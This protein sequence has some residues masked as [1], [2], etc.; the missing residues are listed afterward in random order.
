[1]YR[2]AI[3]ACNGA[4]CR[5]PLVQQAD[6]S[7]HVCRWLVVRHV[8]FGAVSRDMVAIVGSLVERPAIQGL[9]PLDPEVGN[10]QSRQS[11]S[12]CVS[13]PA[14]WSGMKPQGSCTWAGSCLWS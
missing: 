10:T 3:T 5:Q 6:A 8:F 11:E 9:Q 7:V 12:G 4:A 2:G 1:M 14:R 13:S